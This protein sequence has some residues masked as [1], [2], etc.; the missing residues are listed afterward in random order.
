M[1]DLESYFSLS[2]LKEYNRYVKFNK[3]LNEE[4]KGL[5][6]VTEKKPKKHIGIKLMVFAVLSVILSFSFFH[7]ELALWNQKSAILSGVIISTIDVVIVSLYLKLF[8]RKTTILTQEGEDK[9]AQWKAFGRFIDDPKNIC[10]QP[11]SH[12]SDLKKYIAYSMA[13]G[14]D[15]DFNKWHSAALNNYIKD[16]DEDFMLFL[17]LCNSIES[18]EKTFKSYSY[19]GHRFQNSR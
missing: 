2:V 19:N 13:L 7:S 9:L 15:F 8:I 3:Q 16:T 18:M 1:K 17:L 11:L 6:F 12:P 10:T 4:Y 5:D 14:R